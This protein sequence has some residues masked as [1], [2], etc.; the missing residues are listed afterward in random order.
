MSTL[1]DILTPLVLRATVLRVEKSSQPLSAI[2]SKIGGVPYRE[3]GEPWPECLTCKQP[4]SFICQV[5]LRESSH[6]ARDRIPFFTFFYCWKCFPWGDQGEWVVR[7]YTDP[8][9]TKA[10]RIQPPGQVEHAAECPVS[11]SERL[12]LPDWEGAQL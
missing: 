1:D 7:I 3:A 8:M 5:D 2:A 4:L 6:P 11:F 12:S 9:E 10:V